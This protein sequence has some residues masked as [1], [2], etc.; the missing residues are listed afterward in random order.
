MFGHNRNSGIHTLRNYNEAHHAWET[1]K[2]IRGRKEDVRPLG[3]RRCV[4]QYTI[5]K[6]ESGAI[7]C[8]LYKTPVVSYLADGQIVIKDDGWKSVSTAYF[9]EEVLG[10]RARIFNRDL[11]VSFNGGEYPV[12]TDGLY[13]GWVDGRLT[14]L[15]PPKI[16]VHAIDRKGANNVRAK[17]ADFHTYMMGM[18]KLRAND[19]VTTEEVM[20]TGSGVY[21]LDRNYNQKFPEQVQAFFALVNDRNPETQTAS[22]YHASLALVRSFGRYSYKADG[23][24]IPQNTKKIEKKFDE[25]VLGFNRDQA[26]CSRELSLGEVK[27]DNYALY[28]QSGWKRLHEG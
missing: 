1:T 17:Y 23:V 22:W 25:L 15:N 21:D 2:P 16:K 27:R 4:N 9:I 8:V 6:A 20:A 12:P 7:E 26:L 18:M 28:F 24:V 3:H 11:N 5:N 14:P 10:I 19:I 13:L